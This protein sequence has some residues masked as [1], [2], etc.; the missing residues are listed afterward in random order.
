[1]RPPQVGDLPVSR[2]HVG[3]RAGQPYSAGFQFLVLSLGVRP[4]L[5]VGH[6]MQC[7]AQA[8]S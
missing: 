3:S 1:M 4:S 8:T 2:A 5:M 7:L 6:N